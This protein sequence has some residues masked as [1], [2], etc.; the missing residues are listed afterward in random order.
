MKISLPNDVLYILNTLNEAGF[1]AFAV[2]GCVRDSLRGKNPDD[3]DITTAAKP[4]QVMGLF[5]RT[6]PTGLQHGTV[7]VLVN[8][9]AFEVTT[10]R[11][12]GEYSDHR[13]PEQVA[14]TDDVTEDL[15]RRDFTMNA[16][17]YHPET[18]LVDPFG[19]QKDMEAGLIRCVGDPM[20]RFDEDAL[21]MM[22]AVR[23]AA[24]TGFCIDKA[25]L[26][27]MQAQKNLI[28]AVSAERIRDELLKT[29]CSDRPEM[30]EIL[31]DTGILALIL[32]EVDRCFSVAQH[33]KYHIYDVGHHILEVVRNVEN[34][35]V[36]R[37]AALLHDIGKPDMKTTDEAGFDHFKHHD[38]KSVALSDNILTRLRLD[39]HTKE[40]VL[41]LIR[42]HDRRMAATK[43]SVRRAVSRVGADLFPDLLSL[44]R[45]DAKGQEP[46]HG[47]ESLLHYDVVEQLFCEI[48]AEGNA[49]SVKDLAI[50]GHDLM[51]LGFSG[52]QVGATLK[53]AL[54]FVLEH[55]EQNEKEI[56]LSA[57][58]NK[59]F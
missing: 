33:S 51:A 2:G 1:S 52:P 39:N 54:E 31:Y 40:T 25:I 38:E 4:E 58:K 34:K 29:L 24:K 47:K 19:G 18:G 23:F 30:I 50:S 56:L 8:K 32:P 49:L 22:R 15:S 45:A 37:L 36:L 55:P 11:V 7:T 5:P 28:L 46:V 10:F 21:R 20:V 3:W 17:A 44:M 59:I 43:V 9:N 35:Q 14:F 13:R 12:D 27:A 48:V 42:H 41:R 57:I 53:A 16:M 26:T 6:V